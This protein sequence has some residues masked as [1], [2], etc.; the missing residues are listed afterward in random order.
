MDAEIVHQLA[1]RAHAVRPVVLM[2][3]CDL[4]SLAM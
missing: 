2:Q 4:N 3:A 1:D